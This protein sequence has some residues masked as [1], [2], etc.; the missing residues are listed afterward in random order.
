MAV[1]AI[2]ANTIKLVIY[3][4]KEEIEIMKL[5]G[6]TNLFVKIPLIVEGMIQGLLGSMIAVGALYGLFRVF[7]ENYYQ[8]MGLFFGAVE[9]VFFDPFVLA[10]IIAGGVGLGIFGSLISLGRMLKV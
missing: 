8:E 6:A 7:M 4:R 5:V 3:A 9:I 1:I 2:I 10:Y